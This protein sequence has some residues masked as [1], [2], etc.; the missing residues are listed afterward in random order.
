MFVTCSKSI[1]GWGWTAA[2][3]ICKERNADEFQASPVGGCY[4]HLAKHYLCTLRAQHGPGLFDM[5]ITLAPSEDNYG[6]FWNCFSWLIGLFVTHNT[7]C[8]CY[9]LFQVALIFRKLFPLPLSFSSLRKNTVYLWLMVNSHWTCI[10]SIFLIRFWL[11]T[12]TTL[13]TPNHLHTDW[14]TANSCSSYSKH[15][16]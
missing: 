7:S 2:L 4:P 16:H 1:Q 12:F 8:G 14:Y 5:Q 10:Y 6:L 9:N 15:S 3:V 11:T 13:A